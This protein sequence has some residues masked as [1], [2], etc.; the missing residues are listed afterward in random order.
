MVAAFPFFWRAVVVFG[1]SGGVLVVV[2]FLVARGS[3]WRT[4][5]IIKIGGVE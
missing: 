5:S 3:P 4:Q 1:I 2:F